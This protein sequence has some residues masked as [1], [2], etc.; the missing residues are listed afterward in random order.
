G[1]VATTVVHGRMPLTVWPA[2][3]GSRSV[4]PKAGRGSPVDGG[5]TSVSRRFRVIGKGIPPFRCARTEKPDRGLMR[6]GA[7]PRTVQKG[8]LSTERLQPL[9][10]IVAGNDRDGVPIVSRDS[11][12]T[13][14]LDDQRA[15]V[16]EACGRDGRS[17]AGPTVSNQHRGYTTVGAVCWL[18]DQA[19]SARMRPSNRSRSTV[20]QVM[21]S[22]IAFPSA[23]S[24]LP[25]LL[26][27]RE[28]AVVA[29]AATAGAAVPSEH[30]SSM[31]QLTR[32]PAMLASRSRTAVRTPLTTSAIPTV[33]PAM[34]CAAP[35]ALLYT[36]ESSSAFAR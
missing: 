11:G 31:V 30:S 12:S 7:Y 33:R 19:S 20:S 32:E 5:F 2:T 27:T 8:R 21:A 4:P 14:Q 6:T 25:T 35:A 16:R 29:W 26:T 18:S 28:I 17:R 13:R 9:W 24:S 36:A 3:S 22:V 15:F 10:A 23:V 1:P 34:P